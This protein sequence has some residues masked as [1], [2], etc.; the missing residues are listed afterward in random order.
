MTK[1][2]FEL[3]KETMGRPGPSNTTKK[4]ADKY[5]ADLARQ[6]PKPSTRQD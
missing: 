6:P 3:I 5:F 1:T 4:I 2:M